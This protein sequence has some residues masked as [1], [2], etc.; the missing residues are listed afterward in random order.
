MKWFYII[1]L[2]LAGALVYSPMLFLDS[3][4]DRPYAGLVV[5]YREDGTPIRKEQPIVRYD[6][7]GAAV[8][9][10]DPATC[11]DTTSAMI[12]ANFYEGLYTY[13]LLKRDP[14]V[15]VP[16]LAADMPQ[17][18]ADGLTYTIRLKAGVKYSRNACFG[19]EK[20]GQFKTRTV[21]AEDFVLALKRCADYHIQTGLSWAFLSK[22]VRGLDEFRAKCQGIPEEL[23]EAFEAIDASREAGRSES[24]PK[25]VKEAA[26]RV[27]KWVR[28]LYPAPGVEDAFTKIAA[29]VKAPKAEMPSDVKEAF[30]AADEWRKGMG[31]Y[32]AGDFSR[33]DLPV[34]GLR[35]LDELTLQIRLRE[36]FPQFTYVLAMSVYAPIPREAIEYWLARDKGDQPIPVQRRSTEFKASEQVVGTGAYL[37]NIFERKHKI[38]LVRNPEFREDYYPTAGAPGDKEAGLLADAGKRVPFIDVLEYDFMPEAYSTWMRFL[39]K[40]TDAAGIPRETFEFIV[41]PDQ[42]L[43]AEWKKRHIYMRKA[44]SPSV[45]W[46]VFNMEDKVLGTSKS[47]RQALCLA[48]DVENYIKVLRSGRAK[49]AVNILPSNFPKNYPAHDLA[50]PGPYYGLDLDAARKKLEEAKKELAAAGLLKNGEIPKL[51]FDMGDRTPRASSFGEFVRQQ[52]RKVGVEVKVIYNDWP[53]LQS[54]VHNKQSQMYTMGWHADYPDAENFLQL[55]YSP[56]IEKGT[57]NSNYSRPEFDRLYERIRTM[58]DSPERTKLCAEMVNMISQDCPVLLL[59]EPLGFVLIYD[60]VS[61]VKPHPIGYGFAKYRRIDPERR[62]RLGGRR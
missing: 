42:E 18:S 19:T 2:A 26:E 4:P 50:G 57:N 15:V 34:E 23:K 61:N 25:D 53:T 20:D 32:K 10:I 14:L 52:F 47:L 6:S 17:I 59:T 24:T 41:T 37:L 12:Q 62:A 48:F 8:K 46:I 43:A 7:Y 27:A 5:G 30:A 58:A 21:R 22:R 44:W 36:G 56:N 11:G 1:S 29:W 49:R 31:G 33:Y 3:R 39:A 16:Q 54:K 35:S 60:W 45:Y 55:F 28:G 51:T 9:S 40:Q 13:H 38:V